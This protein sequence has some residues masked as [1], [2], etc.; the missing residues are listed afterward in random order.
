MP[1]TDA[2]ARN[3]KPKNK[4]YR[5]TDAHGLCLEV[6]PSGK[7]HWRFRYRFEGRPNMLAIGEYPLVSLAEARE[8]RD[9]A[10]KL[11][12][13]G[14]DPAKEKKAALI[15]R[16]RE[17]ITFKVVAEEWLEKKTSWTPRTIERNTGILA[18]FIYPEIG[19]EPI[20]A[21]EPPVLLAALRKM[22]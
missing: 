17:G 5:L 9:A 20:R 15:A 3:A 13:D 8:K 18:R 2:K 16:E 10:R 14:S 19:E 1:L 11:L 6:K 7:K 4:V 22:E 21:I 12:L